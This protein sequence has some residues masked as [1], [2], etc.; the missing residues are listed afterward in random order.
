MVISLAWLIFYYI[1]RFRYIHAKDRLAVSTHLRQDR[2][3]GTLYD[4][5]PG[6]KGGNERWT[7]ESGRTIISIGPIVPVLIVTTK[8]SVLYSYWYSESSCYHLGHATQQKF[9]IEPSLNENTA[10][11]LIWYALLTLSIVLVRR[12]WCLSGSKYIFWT[13]RIC[14]LFLSSY[15]HCKQEEV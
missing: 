10:N 3:E 7:E 9:E 6:K 4:A 11:T 5:D 8:G 13:C 14:Y 2:W 1:Q 15:H 12:L